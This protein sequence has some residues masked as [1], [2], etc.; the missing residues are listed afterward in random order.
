[1][2]TPADTAQFPLTDPREMFDLSG[3]VTLVTG[4]TRGLGLAI[5]SG[6]AAAGADVIVVSRKLEACEA[7]AAALRA[8]GAR[9][10]GFACHVG[11]WHEL[12]PLLDAVYREFGRIDVLVNNAGMSPLYERLSAV[13]EEHWDKVIGVNLKGPFR[14]CAL[15]GE[16]MAG[17]RGRLDHQHQQHRSGSPDGRYRPL[18]GGQSRRQRDDGRARGG[19]RT[20]GPSQRDH[21]GAVPDEHRQE[22]GHGRARRAH[23][24]LPAAAR[25]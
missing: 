12:E 1:M 25:R 5:A 23:G 9:A 10:K 24:D 13:T 2:S 22:L 4:G 3:R 19:V 11:H 7:V 20:E 14:L 17:S 6:Y 18:R 16:R 8:R 21:A 15:V